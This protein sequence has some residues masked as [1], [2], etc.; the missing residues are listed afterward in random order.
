MPRTPGFDRTD[1]FDRVFLLCLKSD[2]GVREA[3]V[4]ISR[5]VN[6][7]T[8]RECVNNR[9]CEGVCLERIR[10]IQLRAER[11]IKK[12][13]LSKEGSLNYGKD[14]LDGRKFKS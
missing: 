9:V 2:L 10:Q 6:N 7:D 14:K 3:Q 8:L 13:L 5:Y 11:K 1:G 4:I 12:Y